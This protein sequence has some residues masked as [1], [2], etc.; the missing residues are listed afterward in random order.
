M[1][2]RFFVESPI[3]LAATAELRDD[4]AR[5]LTKVMR[6][7]IGDALLLFDGGG[8]EFAA[9]ILRVEK[10]R[11]VCEILQRTEIERE[12]PVQLT[13]AVALPKGDRQRFLIEKL[14]ELGVLRLIPLRTQRG[15]AEAGPSV[16]ERLRRQVIEASKQCGRNRLMEIAAPLDMESLAASVPDSQSRLLAHPGGEPWLT[17]AT[18]LQRE[19]IA[20]I[21]PEGGFTPEECAIAQAAGWKTISLGPRI[22]RVETAA[23]ALAALC[24]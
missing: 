21:G 19:I 1:S 11:V 8:C 15:V 18:S 6:A 7:K 13:L 5:H 2:D 12:S 9:R 10:S 16:L 17:A 4:E 3:E 20:A 22:L 23:L 14:V 24:G